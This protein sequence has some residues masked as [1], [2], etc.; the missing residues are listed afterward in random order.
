MKITTSY[1]IIQNK[2]PIANPNDFL[3][4]DGDSGA[5]GESYADDFSY[6]D[7]SYADDFSYATGK[8][9]KGKKGGKGGHKPKSS[10]SPGVPKPQNNVAKQPD[11]TLPPVI[12]P[13]IVPT[14]PQHKGLSTGAKIGIG[15]GV[16][17]LIGTIVFFIIRHKKKHGK[18]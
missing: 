15:A 12:A 13:V 4:V 16:L 1:P 6:A 2:K 8:K 10:G 11:A 9:K 18:K 3:S 17:V 7:D 14:V 5:D